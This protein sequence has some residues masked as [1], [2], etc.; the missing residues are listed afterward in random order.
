MGSSKG[1]NIFEEQQ[2]LRYDNAAKRIIEG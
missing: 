2:S 1:L